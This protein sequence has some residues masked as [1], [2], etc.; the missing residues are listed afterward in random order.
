MFA[1]IRV[2]KRAEVARAV[3]TFLLF[4]RDCALRNRFGGIA[5]EAEVCVYC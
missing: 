5:Q 4:G 2:A 1:R 3:E